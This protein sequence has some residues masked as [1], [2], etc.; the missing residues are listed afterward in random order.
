MA[1]FLH[2]LGD[3]VS[4]KDPLLNTCDH[5]L[6]YSDAERYKFAHEQITTKK[7]DKEFPCRLYFTK[8]LQ[9]SPE[10]T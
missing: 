7:M 4:M 6:M 5:A 8:G 9:A 10:D 1:S 2:R 3:S